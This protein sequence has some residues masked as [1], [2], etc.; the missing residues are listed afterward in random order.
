MKDRAS[1]LCSCS[2]LENVFLFSSISFRVKIHF[3]LWLFG[4]VIVKPLQFLELLGYLLRPSLVT[5]FSPPPSV[6]FLNYVVLTFLQGG[7]R[8]WW[9]QVGP[10]MGTGS[11]RS[12]CPGE[13]ATPS[14]AF[15]F[16]FL[17]P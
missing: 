17:F 7:L 16:I 4:S 15:S 3:L 6:K 8:G 10:A 14:Y 1:L 2:D 9:Q 11:V 12:V 13:T 5:A